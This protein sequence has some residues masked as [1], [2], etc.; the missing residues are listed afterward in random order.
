MKVGFEVSKSAVRT[1][2][3]VDFPGSGVRTSNLPA[4]WPLKIPSRI[5]QTLVDMTH[6]RVLPLH[7]NLHNSV[8]EILTD[9]FLE[10]HC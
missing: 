3:L 5:K 6:S 9:L 8:I 1:V 4:S 7:E 10:F 2:R